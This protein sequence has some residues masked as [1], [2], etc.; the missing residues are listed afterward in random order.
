M[1]EA[2]I[3]ST[4]ILL[5]LI[6]GVIVVSI[7]VLRIVLKTRRG[8][9]P[10]RKKEPRIIEA[11]SSNHNLDEIFNTIAATKRIATDLKRRGVNISS[12]QSMISKAESHYNEGRDQRARI[13]IDEAKEYLLKL[14]KDW[15]EKIGFDVMPTTSPTKTKPSFKHSIDLKGGD[16][17]ESSKTLKPDEV[18]PELKKAEKK[19]P[20]NFLSSKFTISLAASA[21]EGA[22][23]EGQ[24][25]REA[26]RY[27]FD[28]KVCFERED[29]DDAFQSALCSKR[30]AEE[31]MD[32]APKEGE[33]DRRVMSD[34][35][36]P[37]SDSE[38]LMT[39]STCGRSRLP[40]ICIDVD[41]EEEATCKECYDRTM[42]KIST[43]TAELP[44][45]PPPPPEQIEKEEK[46]EEGDQAFCPNCG[47]KVKASDV[48]C[49]KCGKPVQEELKCVGCGEEVEP[50]DVFCRKCGAR[51]VT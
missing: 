40:Y 2:E 34:L 19:K 32:V 6:I 8:S 48:F 5:I 20:D 39:C 49:G 35:A 15:D 45:P 43:A 4:L 26:E 30:E 23:R 44:P 50:G 21:I 14:K 11:S 36:T 46:E 17:S 3:K 1:T 10:K 51:L 13:A 25:V 37:G 33:D 31:L 38:E 18:F 42:G 47:A 12:A 28:A 22:R 9:S 7:M 16:A 41:G 24:D 27:L 29:Y